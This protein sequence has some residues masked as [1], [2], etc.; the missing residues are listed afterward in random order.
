MSMKRSRYICFHSWKSLDVKA[1]LSRTL[2]ITATSPSLACERKGTSKELMQ[3][4]RHRQNQSH[5]WKERKGGEQTQATEPL[6]AGGLPDRSRTSCLPTGHHAS[7]LASSS[8]LGSGP[9]SRSSFG[10]RNSKPP[11]AYYQPPAFLKVGFTRQSAVCLLF[12]ISPRNTARVRGLR[13]PARPQNSAFFTTGLVMGTSERFH[14]KGLRKDPR[15][16]GNSSSLKI[17]H[18]RWAGWPQPPPTTAVAKRRQKRVKLWHS[19][20]YLLTH[21]RGR[22]RGCIIITGQRFVYREMTGSPYGSG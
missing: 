21:R 1:G 6:K 9:L 20:W 3:V 2:S 12:L 19:C 13:P 18:M 14:R 16:N 8:V 11:T 10:S 7:S 22:G 4:V 17:Q 5:G 15:V